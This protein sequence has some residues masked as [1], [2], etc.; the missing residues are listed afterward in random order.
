MY[1][2]K[3]IFTLILAFN[4]LA[5]AIPEP[6]KK[7]LETKVEIET[8]K[9]LLAESS[10][11][12]FKAD[13][14][15]SEI[16]IAI[17]KRIQFEVCLNS[18]RPDLAKVE[19]GADVTLHLDSESRVLKADD[20][21]CVQ[22][23]ESVAFDSQKEEMTLSRKLEIKDKF[24]KP[25]EVQFQILPNKNKAFL[26]SNEKFKTQEKL[27]LD[28]KNEDDSVEQLELGFE[29]LE[30]DAKVESKKATL[31]LTGSP[32]LN[33]ESLQYGKIKAQLVLFKVKNDKTEVIGKSSVQEGQIKDGL[34]NLTTQI[35]L[36][37]CDQDALFVD[38]RVM[39]KSKKFTI[40]KFREIHS[41]P[42]CS[43]LNG[44]LKL[45]EPETK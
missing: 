33:G 26:L 7:S 16:S 27:S 18:N 13:E 20:K 44:K 1:Q 35:N 34:L 29:T 39:A 5:C 15:D 30:L 12:Q 42:S 45:N 36:A 43:G 3:K 6:E 32:T 25:L 19:A 22:W 10:D 23:E 37:S 14:Y 21:S 4:F 31:V 2:S 8:P 11:P 38:I 17:A 9:L 24:D 28:V 40:Q 41:I